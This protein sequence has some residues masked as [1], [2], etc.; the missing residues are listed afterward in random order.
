[1]RWGLRGDLLKDTPAIAIAAACHK[2][3]T[4]GRTIAPEFC[5]LLLAVAPD[6]SLIGL[7][8]ILHR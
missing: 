2:V 6:L 3:A 8:L 1:M 7:T 4:G 5:I